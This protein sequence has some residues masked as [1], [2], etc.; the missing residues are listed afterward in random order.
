LILDWEHTLVLR[1]KLGEPKDNLKYL[2]DIKLFFGDDENERPDLPI[3]IL[4]KM[5]NLTKMSINY[6]S[7]LEVFQTQIPKNVKERVLTHLKTLK[8]YNVSKLQSIGSEDSPWLN[9]ICDSEKLQKLYVFTCPDLKTLVHSTPLVSFRYVKEMYID[10][11]KELKYLFTLSSVNKL[12][13]LEHIEVSNCKSMQAIVFKED[14]DIS[15]EIKLQQ[16]KRVHIYCLS[17][18]ECFY[19][20]YET[21]RLP[22]LM[23]V[24]IWKCPKMEFFSGGEIH[25]NSSF[26]GIRVSNV[27]SDDMVFYHDLNS[28]VDKVFLQQVTTFNSESISFDSFL[29]EFTKS[30]TR[31]IVGL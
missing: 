10:R 5:P 2:N 21:L 27:L 17:S 1:T 22:S 9:V 11:C 24:D 28:S 26:R 29:S 15:E 18:L 12:E 25:L 16:L 3:Q 4:Q 8:L 30:K 14:D 31:T 6:C 20:G 13:N 23:L 19:S 7:C